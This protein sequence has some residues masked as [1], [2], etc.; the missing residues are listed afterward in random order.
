MT[1]RRA[2]V[3]GAG[4]GIGAAIATRLAREGHRVIVAD[5]DDAATDLAASIGAGYAHLDVT[6][7]VA[8]ADTIAA[9][10]PIEILV[11]NAGFDDIG[12]FT[13]TTPERW[14]RVLDVNLV[15]VL[16][17]THA[18]LP[19]MQRARWGRIVSISSE[20]GRIGAKTNA[21]YAASK[22]AVIAFTKSLARENGRYGITVNTVA[23]GPIDTPLLREMSTH[24]I[25][26]I[27]SSTQL[28]RLGTTDE[29]A[30]AVAFLASD[31]AAYITG[32]T[33]C[34]SGGMGL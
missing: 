25:D 9:V 20:A 30:A 24:A 14:H 4:R 1:E 5:I 29:V 31:D 11:N 16:A 12:W 19:A 26:V 18:V 27:T 23:P 2:L 7:P 13:D 28:G 10:G 32:E 22:G 6:D 8:V 34:V 3:T 21:V 33:L 15:G 17:C